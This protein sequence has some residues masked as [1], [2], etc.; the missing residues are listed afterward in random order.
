MPFFKKMVGPPEPCCKGL[1][2]TVPHFLQQL[3]SFPFEAQYYL[4]SSE[5]V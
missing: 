1:Q 4:D 3:I 5:H 2:V